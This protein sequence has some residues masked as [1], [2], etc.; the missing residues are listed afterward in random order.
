VSSNYESLFRAVESPVMQRIRR[1]GYG[2]DIGQHSWVTADELRADIRRLQ[3]TASSKLIDLGCGPCGPL[4]FVLD[5]TRCAGVGVDVIDAALQVGR[6]RAKSM[7]IGELLETQRADLNGPLPFEASSF[8]A[9]MS[10][11]AVI[12]V[13]E[14]A[15]LFA[16]VARLLRPGGRFL[17]T[18]GG[19]ITGSVS[20]EEMQRRTP[21][22][23]AYFVPPR[24]NERLLEAA[25]LRVIE[26]EDRTASATRN[27]SGRLA[28]T[29]A[30]RADLAQEI[31]D[32]GVDT[33]I[34]FLE[35]VVE[36]SRRHALSR[37]M[38]LVE[39]PR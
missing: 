26:V 1:D 34:S 39:R 17:F 4:T 8:D 21:N 30:Y 10:L 16:E 27:A 33:Q 31:S 18:D 25:G 24:W 37:V 11:D 9:V 7:G 35:T 38:Y 6:A 23:V 3:L 29:R 22:G 14:R 12:H 5:T 36:V 20:N 15:A 2:E 13:G 19:V 28:A 32:E